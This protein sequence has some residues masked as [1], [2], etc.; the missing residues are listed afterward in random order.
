MAEK[1]VIGMEELIG[2]DEKKITVVLNS[3]MEALE[4]AHAASHCKCTIDAVRGVYRSKAC[5]LLGLMSMNITEPMDL[6]FYNFKDD[7]DYVSRFKC[8]EVKN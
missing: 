5:S 8:W 6:I 4:L 3:Q 1:D 2:L 7:G